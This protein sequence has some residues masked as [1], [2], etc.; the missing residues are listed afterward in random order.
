MDKVIVKGIYRF[1]IITSSLIRIEEDQTEK[2]EDRAT[3]V[4]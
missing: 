2:F 4:V 1:S 3:T